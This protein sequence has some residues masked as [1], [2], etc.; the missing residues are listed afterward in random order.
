MIGWPEYSIDLHNWKTGAAALAEVAFALPE[1]ARKVDPKDLPDFD[2]VAGI[3]SSKER[4]DMLKRTSFVVFTLVFAA[5]GLEALECFVTTGAP[6]IAQPAEAVVGRPLTPV[7]VAGV[8][9]RTVRRCAAG[10]YHC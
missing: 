10:V 2:E 6:G 4:T 3:L 8:G 1:G 7:S 5:L 9:R